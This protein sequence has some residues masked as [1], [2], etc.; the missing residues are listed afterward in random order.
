MDSTQ[1]TKLFL[2]TANLDEISLY[3]SNPLV[4]G[5][6]TNPTLMRS[7]GI[8]NYLNFA[9]KIIELVRPLP[10]SLEVFADDEEKIYRQ[11][12]VLSSM[13]ENLYVKIPVTTTQG[14]F[15]TQVAKRLNNESVKLNLTALMTVSQIS[16]YTKILDKNMENIF[17]IFCGRLADCGT[18]PVPVVKE[19]IKLI[20][21]V[22]SW[23][24]LWASPREIFNLIQARNIGC[25]LITMTP[26]LWKKLPLLGK[27]PEIFSLETVQMFHRD[28]LAAKYWI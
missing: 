16:E 5:F 26:E 7:A 1:D 25:H 9:Q 14:M 6:T 4:S 11:A 20:K 21:K 10:L 2:D 23:R 27:N 28:A 24:I 15:L 13:Y 8:E 3:R 12:K 18:D 17:S 19:S 22:E